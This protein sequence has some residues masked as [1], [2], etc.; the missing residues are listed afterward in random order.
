MNKPPLCFTKSKA[1]PSPVYPV[2]VVL[3]DPIR[4]KI[5]MTSSTSNWFSYVASCH[6]LL[7]EYLTLY[8]LCLQ[9]SRERNTKDLSLLRHFEAASPLLNKQGSVSSALSSMLEPGLSPSSRE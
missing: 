1:A 7:F 8:S 2:H 5:Q 6:T 9:L 4:P 3:L